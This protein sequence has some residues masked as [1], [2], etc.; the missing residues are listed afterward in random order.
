MTGV[1]QKEFIIDSEDKV[2]L[3][4]DYFN[5]SIAPPFNQ[6]FQA[7]SIDRINFPFVW[8]NVRN[9]VN[10]VFNLSFNATWSGGYKEYEVSIKL[11]VIN[12]MLN[13]QDLSQFF[14]LYLSSTALGSSQKILEKAIK[15]KYPTYVADGGQPIFFRLFWKNNT[16]KGTTGF[17][18]ETKVTTAWDG[19]TTAPAPDRDINISSVTGSF[20]RFLG[21]DSSE[22]P[23]N[24]VLSIVNP[25]LNTKIYSGLTHI[26]N[27]LPSHLYV[28]SRLLTRHSN[29][30]QS[31]KPNLLVSVPLQQYAP[32]SNV[33]Y[34]CKRWFSYHPTMNEDVD[35]FLEDS[36]GPISSNHSN[37]RLHIVTT[38]HK[39]GEEGLYNHY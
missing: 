25:S 7:I 21:F 6:N 11:P 9:G 2:S 34:R 14:N 22:N 16:K 10:D 19:G 33:D 18:I 15:D 32:N 26:P 24:N 30:V 20:S 1:S 31:I 12:Y 38:L 29:V 13:A 37:H 3:K 28:S 23:Q 36:F 17:S 39:H 35:I 4:N 5:F 8:S 27:V